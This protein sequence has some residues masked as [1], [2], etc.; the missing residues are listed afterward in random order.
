MNENLCPILTKYAV[1]CP[2]CKTTMI[3]MVSGSV[4]FLGDQ[5]TG[6]NNYFAC[7]CGVEVMAGYNGGWGSNT[8]VIGK[9][10]ESYYGES[11]TKTKFKWHTIVDKGSEPTEQ[12]IINA[13][14]K[15]YNG[16]ND[17]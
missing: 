3:L 9:R 17:K 13:V 11:D 6:Y 16:G 7:E 12:Y 4:Q 8:V 2:K 1:P 15:A 10:G 5:S 14:L